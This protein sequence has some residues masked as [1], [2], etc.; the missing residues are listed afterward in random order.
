MNE[1]Q[2]LVS[3][4]MPVYNAENYV[5]KAIISV[6]EQT[7]TNLELILIN[8]GST[9]NSLNIMKEFH[10]KDKRIKLISRENRGLVYSLNEGVKSALGE[11]IV[12]MDADDICM[13]NRIEKQVNFMN[14]RKEVG[15]C[16][17][18]VQFF[19]ENIKSD[20]WKLP[21]TSEELKVRLLFSVP[22]AH[23]SVIIR[24]KLLLDYKLYYDEDFKHAED[25][26]LWS[27][28]VEYTDLANLPE[29]ILKYRL[30]STSVTYLAENAKD[31]K[32]YQTIKKI[33][34]KTLKRLEIENEDKL[35]K[36]H[37]ILCSDDRIKTENLDFK[38]IHF[39]F[40]KIIEANKSKKIYEEKALENFL[41]GLY[42]KA[43]VLNFPRYKNKALH[44]LISPFFY[45]GLFF[46][47]LKKINLNWYNVH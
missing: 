7:Y 40:L 16:G 35:N 8:D 33:F 32:R 41:S 17:G 27:R 20:I 19:G 6:L 13:L 9:D 30:S 5:E 18:W 29:V 46:L 11:Y 10:K 25:F 43:F 31:D 3:V 26:E 12:R 42:F 34:S 4:V 36:V 23:P 14:Q 47:T 39:Y 38:V 1:K 24:K 15:V 44:S 37:Y 2:T 45:K 21:L 22:L 28:V